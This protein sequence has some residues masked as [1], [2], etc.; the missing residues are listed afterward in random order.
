MLGINANF[1]NCPAGNQPIGPVEW[2]PNPIRPDS[3]YPFPHGR[4][5]QIADWP[6][7]KEN[8]DVSLPRNVDARVLLAE[9]NLCAKGK[10][11][12]ARTVQ[13]APAYEQPRT[14][15]ANHH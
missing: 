12:D 5:L 15:Q 7:H 4:Q 11:A 13:A 8:I 3:E 1:M 10:F 2:G 6:K 9:P 14:D